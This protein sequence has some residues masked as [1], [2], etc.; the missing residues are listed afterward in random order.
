M[1]PVWIGGCR[2][3]KVKFAA[4]SAETRHLN[5]DRRLDSG[6]SAAVV[7]AQST[8]D[9]AGLKGAGTPHSNDAAQLSQCCHFTLRMWR[10]RRE[11]AARKPQSSESRLWAVSGSA[12]RGPRDGTEVSRMG[13]L[14]KGHV[15]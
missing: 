14:T 5:L 10:A 6:S 8:L 15:I 3:G 7:Q 13:H 4:R 9:L 2:A 12:A 11:P 1:I